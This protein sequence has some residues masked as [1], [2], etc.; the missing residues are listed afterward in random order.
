M[1]QYKILNSVWF[2]PPLNDIFID[3][4]TGMANGI[5]IGIVAIESYAPDGSWKCYI[6]YGNGQSEYGDAQK[7]AGGGMPLGS[8]EAAHGFFPELPI[9]KYRY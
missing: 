9:E 1:R 7:I 4:L 8:A 3:A 6:G 5:C 2:T